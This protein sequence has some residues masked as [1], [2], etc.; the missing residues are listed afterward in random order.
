MQRPGRLEAAK[1]WVPTYQGK[2]IVRGYAR[3][4]RVDLGCALKELQHLGVPLD[5]AYVERLRLT[6][7]NRSR[8]R[9]AAPSSTAGVP[10]GHGSEW[11]DTFAYTAGFTEG[12][13][14]FGVT[15]EEWQAA[16]HV[17]E[18][19][20]GSVVNASAEHDDDFAFVVGVTADGAPFG[21]TWDDWLDAEPPVEGRGDAERDQEP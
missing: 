7:K 4:F 18:E 17:D 6:L 15:W 10:D 21:V 1:R 14:P 19:R 11:D 12:S 2:N 13:T 8:P 20:D 3:W 16:R 9:R 5:P